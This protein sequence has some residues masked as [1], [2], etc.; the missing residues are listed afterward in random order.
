MINQVKI[1]VIGDLGFYAST[2]IHFLFS[3]S[4]C[5][6]QLFN[7][8]TMYDKMRQ[9][10]HRTVGEID[11]VINRWSITVVERLHTT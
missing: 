3:V 8:N 7:P 6:F 1:G 10:E 5:I 2:S 11:L 9:T 4:E